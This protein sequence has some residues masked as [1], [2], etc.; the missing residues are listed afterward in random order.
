MK[1][2]LD[3]LQQT[4]YL[5]D[6]VYA[7]HDSYQIWIVTHNGIETQDAIAL[8]EGTFQ[9]LVAYRNKLRAGK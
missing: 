3:E 1:I 6:G 9:A 5:G 7:G 4:E 2:K 8:E